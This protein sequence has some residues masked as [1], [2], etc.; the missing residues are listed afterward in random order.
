[1]YLCGLGDVDDDGYRDLVAGA[2]FGNGG[3]PVWNSGYARVFSGRTG[4][5][6]MT[7]HGTQSDSR[8]GWCVGNAG[9]VDKDG[10]DDVI[11]GAH[12]HDGVGADSGR[13][14]VFSG[15]DA[16]L[17]WTFDGEA[18]GDQFGW[19]VARAGDV[20]GDGH[21]DLI[22]GARWAD[23]NGVDSGSAHIFSGLDGS[24]LVR[25]DGHSEGDWFGFAVGPAG[26][27]DGNGF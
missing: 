6:L 26:D 16:S 13:A 19:S 17:L 14:F 21:A 23:T 15:A 9:D 11:V 22:V 8:F 12:L 1:W 3:G 25:L 7:L 4:T 5:V 27:I 18:A 24:E 20:N 10:H 2:P